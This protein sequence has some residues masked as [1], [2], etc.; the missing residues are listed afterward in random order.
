MYRQKI[1]DE[2]RALEE[3]RKQAHGL[4]GEVSP[5]EYEDDISWMKNYQRLKEYLERELERNATR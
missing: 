3:L 1:A 2:F 4:D 5:D